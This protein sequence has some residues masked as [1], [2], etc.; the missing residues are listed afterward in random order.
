MFSIGFGLFFIY[1]LAFDALPRWLLGA[2]A[3]IHMMVDLD[4][5]TALSLAREHGH[6]ACAA[7]LEA[8]EATA[9]GN[10]WF[11]FSFWI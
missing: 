5:D 2:G 9:Q 4:G 11:Y 8:A 6:P 10:A 3:D 1:T 7:L